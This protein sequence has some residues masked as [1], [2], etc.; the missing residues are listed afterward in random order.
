MR[1]ADDNKLSKR[2]FILPF[3]K[4]ARDA[5]AVLNDAFE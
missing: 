3:V 2:S 4:G 5:I 1:P